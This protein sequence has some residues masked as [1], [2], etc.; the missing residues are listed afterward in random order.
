MRGDGRRCRRTSERSSI[1]RSPRPASSRWSPPA[2][3]PRALPVSPMRS[4]PDAAPRSR[5][6]LCVDASPAT[7]TK[8]TGEL[9]MSPPTISPPYMSMRRASP[10]TARS[11]PPRRGPHRALGLRRRSCLQPMAATSL[12]L[13]ARAFHPMSRHDARSVLKWTP[14]TIVSVVSTR[15]PGPL[16]QTAASSPT[17]RMS[18]NPPSPLTPGA[19]PALAAI[20]RAITSMV[21]VSPISARRMMP[22]IIWAA[23]VVLNVPWGHAVVPPQAEPAAGPPSLKLDGS[24]QTSC[25]LGRCK[26]LRISRTAP[27][28]RTIMCSL[29]VTDTFAMKFVHF[30]DLHLDSVFAWMGE[31]GSKRRQALRDTLN[32]IVN[33]AVEVEADAVL[34]GGDLYEQ[35]R[36]T[37]D[38][39]AFLQSTFER[40]HPIRVFIAPGNH[41]WY[42]PQSLYRQVTWSENVRVFDSS[43]F[44]PFEVID[45]LTL[46]GAAHRAPANTPGFLEEFEVD[47]GGVNIALFHGSERGWFSQ[48][49]GRKTLHAPFDSD[50]I[51]SSGLDH[52][53]LGHYHRP[54]DDLRFTYP[55]N[56]DPLTFGE[57][58]ERGAVVATV[59]D[60]GVVV[61]DRRRVSVTQVHDLPGGHYRFGKSTGCTRPR[62]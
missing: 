6:S 19:V 14:S 17:E 31:A 15:V 7:V 35:E 12:R 52:A 1:S 33:L 3:S 22:P 47:R 60:D 38:T 44:Q 10:R 46:W 51:E 61:R 62:T 39:A 27:I 28:V 42:G 25:C 36:F 59:M 26:E 16:S 49:G 48:E 41:D 18:L 29:N 20:V 21:P 4:P 30:S 32:N 43:R 45:G 53:F 57:D 13:T 58:G 50:Q 9:T 56:P 55:G 40:L 37:P 34:C 54:R 8:S 23:A 2:D 5:T 11:P 24:H